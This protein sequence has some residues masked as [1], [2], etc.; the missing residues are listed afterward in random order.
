[1]L[2]GAGK[3]G[4]RGRDKS[5]DPW[6]KR[7][8]EGQRLNLPVNLHTSHACPEPGML[9]MG[10]LQNGEALENRT[11]TGKLPAGGDVALVVSA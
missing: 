8:G 4:P 10:P 2:R 7:V 3:R 5:G 1:M 9:R 11:K 6:Q